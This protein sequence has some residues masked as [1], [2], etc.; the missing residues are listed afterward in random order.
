MGVF[1]DT[2]SSSFQ[3]WSSRSPYYPN[4][5]NQVLSE[6]DKLALEEAIT[7]VKTRI[8]IPEKFTEFTYELNSQYSSAKN[9]WMTYPL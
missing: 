1:M 8:S 9:L 3:N 6:T 5:S 7:V 4:S 2:A